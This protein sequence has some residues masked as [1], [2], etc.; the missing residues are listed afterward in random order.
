MSAS[1]N[2]FLTFVL[3]QQLYGIKIIKIREILTYTGITDIPD[4]KPWVKG[5]IDIR[6]E[7][8]PIIDLR[9]RFKVS[10]DPVYSSK[11][12]I[13]ATKTESGRLVG[14]IVDEVSDIETVNLDQIMPSSSDSMI[15]ARF[16]AGYLRKENKMIVLLDTDKIVSEN[17]MATLSQ[18]TQ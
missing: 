12:V 7:A 3:G 11:T 5:V 9:I 13:I 1:D 14:Y 10:E 8:A 6:G 15:D 16:L 17:D 4:S 2:M 18:M